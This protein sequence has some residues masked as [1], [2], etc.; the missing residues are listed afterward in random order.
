M[1]TNDKNLSVFW[2]KRIHFRCFK[3][4]CFG[5]LSSCYSRPRK[6]IDEEVFLE[7][8]FK[9]VTEPW[10][11]PQKS[12]CGQ[13]LQQDA[14]HPTLYRCRLPACLLEVGRE[15]GGG[16]GKAGSTRHCPSAPTEVSERPVN[17]QANREEEE[18]WGRRKE[19]VEETEGIG[20]G[21]ETSGGE[22]RGEGKRGRDK[23][24]LCYV[25]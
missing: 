25:R 2:P 21:E 13:V 20:Q 3:P 9:Q 15:R 5:N 16:G 8:K 6:R 1:K 11:L 22:E 10:L 4:S 19:G 14:S 24:G 23:Q 7:R 12:R 18:E 17:V